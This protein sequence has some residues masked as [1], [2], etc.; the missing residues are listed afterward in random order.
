MKGPDL[1]AGRCSEEDG[2]LLASERT[3]ESGGDRGVLEAQ[4]AAASCM[5]W[6]P[7]HGMQ[8]DA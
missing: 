5:M 3:F 1:W 6:G 2:V 8:D 7:F 4:C